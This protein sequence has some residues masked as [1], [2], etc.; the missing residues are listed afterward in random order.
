MNTAYIGRV[1]RTLALL[2]LALALGGCG[3][4][5]ES[6]ERPPPP[7]AAEPQRAELNWREFH[8][9]RIGQR[10]VFEV[11]TL[12]VTLDGWSARIA[13]TN[14]TDLRFEIETGPGD[15]S[16]G[17]MLF[18][19]GDLK[20]V[21]EANR[22]GVLPAIRR[23]IELEPAPPTFLQP[24]QTWRTTMSAPG[25]LVDGS[26]VRVVFGTFVG[27]KDAPDEFKRV[28]WFTDHAYHL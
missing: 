24:G 11:E 15:Y 10:L 2:A 19:T 5:E 21:Q 25:S 7:H 6:G 22:Q 13:V 12:A 20:T 26:W 8:P 18:P 28:V 14:H 27:E 23:A 3:T 1:R 17:L 16:F 4:A 9:T